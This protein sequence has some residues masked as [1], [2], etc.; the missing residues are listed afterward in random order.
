M[1]LVSTTITAF[2]PAGIVASENPII[3]E[4]RTASGGTSSFSSGRF[5]VTSTSTNSVTVVFNLSGTT[6][7]IKTFTGKNF[8][9]NDSYFLTGTLQDQNGNTIDSS[10]TTS[11]IASSLSDCLNDDIVISRDYYV[12]YTG[13]TKVLLT[14]KEASSNHRLDGGRVTCSTG[15]ITFTSIST[16]HSI[17]QGASIQDYSL[18]TELYKG[19]DNLQLGQSLNVN[20]FKKIGELILPFSSDN[21][22]RFNVATLCKS[23]VSTP[24]PDFS[25]TGSTVVAGPLPFYASFG[26]QYPLVA[27][28]NTTKKL[29]KGRTPYFYVANASLPFISGNSMLAYSGTSSPSAAKF[30]TNQPVTKKINRSQ[31]ELLYILIPK[32]IGGAGYFVIAEIKYWDGTITTQNLYDL[33]TGATN[34]GGLYV[35]NVSYDSVL[36]QFEATGKRIKTAKVWVSNIG[37]SYSANQTYSFDYEDIN[38]DGF[39]VVFLNALGG[40]DTFQFNGVT[41]ETIDRSSKTLTTPL[42]WNRDGSIQ[43]GFKYS[44][45]YDVRVTKRVNVNTGFINQQTFDW[46]IELLGSNEIYQYSGNMN[47]LKL[48]SYKYSKDNQTNEYSVDVSFIQTIFENNVSI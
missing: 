37:F 13:G 21:V 10:I 25:I 36:N 47:Y 7:Y 40:Y 32:N 15:A 46:L 2:Q 11:Q 43:S 44:N 27:G 42:E 3:L 17:Y 9:N 12:T 5:N 19:D 4:L 28:T 29:Y 8:P 45:N 20:Q 31:N 23:F 22:H 34:T 16:G 41:E 33:F 39:G 38:E 6:N 30:L 26:E 35:L 24:R 18:Y 14:A 1:S 48:D